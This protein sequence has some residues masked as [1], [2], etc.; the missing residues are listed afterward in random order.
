LVRVGYF[1]IISHLS[2]EGLFQNIEMT[3]LSYLDVADQSCRRIGKRRRDPGPVVGMSSEEERRNVL[4]KARELQYSTYK[5]VKIV[6]DLTKNQRA[7]EARMKDE[8]DRRN[9]DLTEE[10]REKKR[11]MAGDW[12]DRNR[13]DRNGRA[14]AA[15][16]NQREQDERAYRATGNRKKEGG[17]WTTNSRE[18]NYRGARDG[19]WYRK[20]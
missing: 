2:Y 15:E 3:N 16:R 6:P 20:E 10:D 12:K 18:R 19:H 8:A 14:G 1:Q 17:A 4:E 11:Q 9:R 7:E 13:G 5:N